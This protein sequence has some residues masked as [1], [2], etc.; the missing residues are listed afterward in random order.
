MNEP[1]SML[2]RQNESHA[3]KKIKS[4]PTRLQ[5]GFTLIELLVV[6]AIIA[7]LAGLLL[8]ALGK[9]KI[10]AQRI[11]CVNNLRQLAY[12]W[13]MYAGDNND[14][15][16]S[17]YPGTTIPLGGPPPA[18]LASW[19]YGDASKSGGPGSYG[20]YGYDPKGIQAGVIWPYVTQLGVYKCPADKRT[21]L[22]GGTNM[23]ILRSVSMNSY[24]FGRNYGDSAG[25]D[26]Q[27]ANGGP[28]SGNYK[29]RI[30]W[31]ESQMTAPSRTFIVLDEDPESLNDAMFLVDAGGAGRGLVDLPSRLHDYGYG[32]N[33][34][35]GHA[36]IYQFKDKGWA[37]AWVPGG[38][39]GYNADWR[40]IFD[41]TTQPN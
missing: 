23:P 26:Y 16:A 8:P 19:C 28:P 25:W 37:K 31:K 11:Q 12:G 39:W 41:V 7:I 32:I 29:Y 4:S 13:K 24:L 35:D 3:V 20:Y 30:F 33:F 38:T 21:V 5:R 10:R 27:T 9:A 18:F 15:I 6:I 22:V 2:S 14:R 34:A 36:Q 17:S 1:S 40:Q